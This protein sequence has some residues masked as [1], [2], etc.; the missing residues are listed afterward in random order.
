MMLRFSIVKKFVFAFLVLSL[1]PL[2]VLG[3]STLHG[4][5]AIGQR[6]IDSSTVQLEKRARESLELRAIELANRV[7]QT[8]HS[9]EADLL[10]LKMLPPDPAAYR[11][12]SLNHRKTVWTREG[13]NEHSV[14]VHREIPAYREVA[15]IG[16]DGMEKVR[17]EDDRIVH[18]SELRNVS[19]PENTTYKSER[20]FEEARKLKDGEIYVSHV[21]GWYVSRTEQLQGARNVED[22][23]E[24]KKFEGVVRFATSYIGD[25]GEFEGMVLLSL[26][27][28]HLMELTLHI[29]P[30]EER[31]VVFPSYSSGN[32]AFMF[33]DDGWIISHPK[34]YDIRG[35]RPDGS[36]FDASAP[37][38]TRERLLEGEIPFNLDAVSFINPNY[39]LMAREVRA[40]RSGVTNTFNVG[41]TPRVM[42]YAPIV[43]RQPP[44][45][46][47]GVFGG[48]TIGVQTEKFKEPALLA[49]AKIDEM[50]NQTKQNSII[51]LGGTALV[52]VLLAIFLARTITRP[53]YYLARKAREIAAGHIPDDVA[54]HT[55][56]ELELLAQN[57]SD[58]A[59]E[60]RDHQENLEQSLA[61]LA[62]SKKAVEQYSRELE[63]QLKV[64]NNV[65][66][67]SQY[68]STVYD[69]ELVLQKV[70]KTCVE[71]LGY[72]RAILYLY[73]HPTRRLI[74]HCTCGFSPRDEELAMAV[75]Y[76]IDR[77]ECIPT[78][79]FRLGETIFV[80]DIRTEQRAT[81]L[82]LKI[83]E[84]G[85]IDFFVFTPLKSRDRVI[86]ILGADTKKSRREIREI[87][88]ESL[89]ILANDAARAMERSEL[90]GRLVAERNLVKSVVNQMTSGIITLDEAGRV[91]WFNSYSESVFRIKRTDALGKR[92]GKVF[93]HFPTWVE[94]IDHY[95]ASRE[96]EQRSLEH[97][98]I[99][100]DDREKVLEVHFSTIY[101]EKQRETTCLLF[102]RDITQRKRMEDHIRRSDRLVSLGV[103]AAGIAHEMRNPLTGISLLMDDFHDRLHDRPQE[104]DLIQRSLQEIDRLENLINGLLDFAVPSR[105][106]SLEVRPFGD[107]LKNT[108]F[109]V[110][111]LCKNQNIALS[112]HSDESIPL[113]HLDPEKLQQ[114][115]LNLLLNAIQAMPDGGKLQLEVK[116]VMADESLLS[117]PAV[118]I[119]VADTGRGI[120]SEDIPYIFD[121]FFTRTP[122][123]CGLGLAIVHSIVEEHK[124][125][126]SVSSQ[127]GRGTTF[128]VDLPVVGAAGADEHAKTDPEM[129]E[130]RRAA[131]A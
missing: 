66:Y 117:E 26:D 35:I 114:A 12:F 130:V 67:L 96:R 7:S 100:H 81:P 6:A 80:R 124:G 129:D 116:N 1:L 9:C 22:A 82:D 68:L 73:D 19:K 87:E 46:R 76:D 50:V 126:T 32:Y 37:S 61:E 108:L 41:G 29:L 125:R 91:T 90:Y 109:L 69:R 21:T 42:A 102:I 106:V 121:P 49:S 70:L 36:E 75:S 45:N 110:K 103:L 23:V 74:C 79:V 101:Q 93:E 105:R 28:R 119:A 4:L 78:K 128:W 52:A 39:P 14:E 71:G 72:D 123:G 55:G 38:Y 60:I 3:V 92:Y 20:Y 33:D 2:C 99:F 83:A 122:S 86:G 64:L 10:T 11:Q 59:R 17:I 25:S 98:S 88:V 27:H 31:F 107:V 115:L 53:I 94:V 48:I 118:R 111:K 89:Q 112:V 34:F 131:H 30:T 51:I 104:R 44:Y 18:V 56:D 62:K 65:H 16:P 113:L 8:L 15:L 58:M 5:R 54:V 40:G 47:Y 120:S 57:F 85:E 84:A 127:L 77:H 43:Y 97:H 95:L 13:A 24:G 63:K